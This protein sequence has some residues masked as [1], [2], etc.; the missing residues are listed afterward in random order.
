MNKNWDLDKVLVSSK[1]TLP[2]MAD[3]LSAIS[4]LSLNF[5][6]EFHVADAAL[7]LAMWQRHVLS[8]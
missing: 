1:S 6:R 4:L 8:H 3:H 2:E 7:E 5:L